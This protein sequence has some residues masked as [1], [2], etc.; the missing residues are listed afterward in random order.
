MAQSVAPESSQRQRE[1]KSEQDQEQPAA[2]APG[3][4]CGGRGVHGDACGRRARIRVRH[5]QSGPVHPLGQHVPLQPRR[6]RR[7]ARQQDRQLGGLRRRHLQLQH[8]ATSVANRLDVLSELDVVWKKQL[9]V[10]PERRGLVR[11]R[12]RRRQPQQPEPAARRT[13]RAIR[14]G[15][16][17]HYT[18]RFYHGAVGR[19]ARRVRVR[20]LRPRH[21]AHVAQGRP[22]SP[23]LGRVAVPRRQPPRHRLRAEPARPAEGVRHAGQR[24]EGAVPAA[25]PG[26]GRGPGHRYAFR[27]PRSTSGVGGVPLPGRR[28]LPRPGRLRLQ[29]PGAPVPPAPAL[30]FATRGNAFEPGQRGEWGLS[31]RWSPEWLDGTLGLLLPQLRRQAAADPADAGR[32]Q[33]QRLQP[34]LQGRHRPV[35]RQPREEHRRRQRRAPSS[36]TATT[37]RSTRRCSATLAAGMPAPTA[38][39]RARSATP[40]TA[41]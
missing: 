29:R 34:D 16:T 7:G 13:S 40:T 27:S 15:S 32:S 25:G 30:G 22:P 2:G 36:R 17:R 20:E 10:P 3:C 8:A 23:V 38:D 31:A 18:K 1:E 12:V 28:H 41:S 37:R 6:A 11:R 39:A 14:T 5:R 9:R 4:R 26:L 35:G 21:R 33:P 19:A 24:S